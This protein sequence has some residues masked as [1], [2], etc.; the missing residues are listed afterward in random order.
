MELITA[1]FSNPATAWAFVGAV[2]IIIEVTLVPMMGCLFAGLG[3]LTL[4]GFMAYGVVPM[5]T[6]IPLQIAYSFGLTIVWAGI[7]WVPLRRWMNGRDSEGYTDIVGQVAVVEGGKP[8]EKGEAG[9][10]RW[11]GAAM[12]AMLPS[13]CPRDK[14]RV[15][16]K[17]YI[18]GKKGN[19][20]YVSPTTLA[21]PDKQTIDT[22]RKKDKFH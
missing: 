22:Y 19:T 21:M 9:K 17:V 13:D 2:F 12:N 15:G 18:I 7:L 14:I 11:S 3:A 5:A 6:A 20:L 8:L 1:F 10:V 4:S 16:E